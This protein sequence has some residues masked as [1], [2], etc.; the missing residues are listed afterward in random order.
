MKRHIMKAAMLLTG[1][2][3][4]GEA[5]R[6][7][8]QGYSNPQPFGQVAQPVVSPYINLLR[9]GNPAYLNYAGIVRPQVDFFNSIQSIQ[10][11]VLG[12]QLAISSFATSQ[13]P[14]YTGHPAY[15]LNTSH[16]FQSYG[17]GVTGAGATTAAQQATTSSALA[18]PP[19]Q[20]R[21]SSRSR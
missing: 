21:Y 9:R 1:L 16:Y 10:S 18:V 11:Q 19:P 14:L 6:L 4:W 5:S 13:G 17:G 7:Q 8:A 15:F 3:A 2:V 12:N 20:S